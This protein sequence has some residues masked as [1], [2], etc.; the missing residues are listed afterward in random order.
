[1]FIS[2]TS[3]LLAAYVSTAFAAPLDTLE[4]NA[5]V[6]RGP[7]TKTC[8]AK[9]GVK[10][11]LE[12]PRRSVANQVVDIFRR[13]E[14]VFIGWHGTNEV[15]AK[16][17]TS[18]GSI[19]KPEGEKGR[20]GLDAELG[21]GL[22]LTDTLSVAESAAAINAANNKVGG[23]VCAVYAKSKSAWV[24]NVLKA[25]IPETLRGNGKEDLRKRYLLHVS[26]SNAAA[27]KLGP[28][29]IG[30]NQMLIPE[31]VNPSLQAKCF[32]VDA[33]GDSAGAKALGVS[34]SYGSAALKTE[35]R[36]I[37]AD[38]ETAAHTLAADNIVKG[39]KGQQDDCV[40]S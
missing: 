26:G 22:Y 34:L 32:D 28:L 39:Q 29:A 12:M 33:K 14:S 8:P 18:H 11:S 6:A 20:S 27:A 25:E 9:A 35:W 3:V 30:K 36:V 40:V 23:K 31:S 17:W 38:S 24:N 16:L 5:L 10:R 2:L 19:V 1:M 37:A 21:P 4:M 15:T 13:D 7:Q